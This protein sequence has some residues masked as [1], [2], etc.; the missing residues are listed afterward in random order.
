M[1][2]NVDGWLDSHYTAFVF[3]RHTSTVRYLK[4]LLN[5]PIVVSGSCH[6][7]L[8]VWD[9]QHGRMLHIL[10]GHVGSVCSLHVCGN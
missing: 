9:V 3:C 7:T 10:T 5:R 1:G 2:Q 4:V 8:R 6:D